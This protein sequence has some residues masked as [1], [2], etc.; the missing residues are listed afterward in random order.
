MTLPLLAPT[1]FFVVTTTLITTLQ[2]FSEVFVMTPTPGGG[3]NNATMT[4]VL[5]LYQL[6][7]NRFEQGYAAAVAWVVFFFIFAITLVQF[8][9]QRRYGEM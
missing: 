7:F 3:P 8:R 5:Y 1:T 9:I 4:A 6:G 2:V